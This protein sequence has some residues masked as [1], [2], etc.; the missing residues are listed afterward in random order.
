MLEPK[1]LVESKL[2]V[3]LNDAPEFH[4]VESTDLRLRSLLLPPLISAMT[5]E[6]KQKI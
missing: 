3:E 2:V 1:E 5:E 4:L 6:T